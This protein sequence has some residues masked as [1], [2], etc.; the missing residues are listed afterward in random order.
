MASRV[1]NCDPDTLCS[2]PCQT[3]TSLHDSTTLAVASDELSTWTTTMDRSW[4]VRKAMAPPPWNAHLQASGFGLPKTRRQYDSRH[5][6][7]VLRRSNRESDGL[8]RIQF[9]FL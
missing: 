5:Q 3:L 6:H 9:A 2:E 4:G 7:L 8:Q 1:T